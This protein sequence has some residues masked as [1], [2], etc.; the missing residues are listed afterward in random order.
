MA[1]TLKT[2]K[3][4]PADA[5]LLREF[6]GRLQINETEAIRL[7]LPTRTQADF[8]V[9]CGHWYDAA[10]KTAVETFWDFVGFAAI[11]Y[12]KQ[13]GSLRINSIQAAQQTPEAA[14]RLLTAAMKAARGEPGYELVPADFDPGTNLV[15]TPETDGDLATEE[16][17][18]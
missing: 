7:L 2:F 10:G 13:N 3:L 18:E 9:E 16:F 17:S 4:D 1:K 15:K 6:A 14:I 5:D 11:Q 12:A 8:I